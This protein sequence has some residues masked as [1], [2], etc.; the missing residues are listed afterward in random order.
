MCSCTVSRA[1]HVVVSFDSLPLAQTTEL[2]ALCSDRGFGEVSE[3]FSKGPPTLGSACRP[4]VAVFCNRLG[5][6]EHAKC[7]HEQREQFAAARVFLSA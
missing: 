2:V 5:G 1:S 4:R 6:F 7:C 3:L